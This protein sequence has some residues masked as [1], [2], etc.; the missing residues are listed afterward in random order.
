MGSLS[1]FALA[2]FHLS[3]FPNIEFVK[4]KT[5]LPTSCDGPCTAL[6]WD[7]VPDAFRPGRCPEPHSVRLEFYKTKKTKL[8]YSK[9]YMNDM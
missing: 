4:T 3:E 1:V 7:T 8:R 6:S 9:S 5:K 2:H